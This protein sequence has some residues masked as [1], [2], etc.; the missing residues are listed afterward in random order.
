[1]KF[2]YKNTSFLEEKISAKT[3]EIDIYNPKDWVLLSW[4]Y[5]N[6]ASIPKSCENLGW[7]S[8]ICIIEDVNAGEKFLSTLP[9]GEDIREKYRKNSDKNGVCIENKNQLL[10]ASDG[11]Q[12]I[13]VIDPPLALSINY[14][15]K[16]ISKK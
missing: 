12:G 15:N 1:M 4:P 16:I 6:E 5:K 2:L 14:E 9:F 8:C 13:I 3:T 11:D 10:V 7:E